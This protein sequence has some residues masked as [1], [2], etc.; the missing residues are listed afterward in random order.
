MCTREFKLP[1]SGCSSSADCR[2][3]HDVF[4]SHPL[5]STTPTDKRFLFKGDVR[6]AAIVV[7]QLHSAFFVSDSLFWAAMRIPLE[8]IKDKFITKEEVYDSISFSLHYNNLNPLLAIWL[9]SS[10]HSCSCHFK[11]YDSLK[12]I[13]RRCQVFGATAARL[14]LYQWTF[15][16]WFLILLFA[17][18]WMRWMKETAESILGLVIGTS[19]KFWCNYSFQRWLSHQDIRI[20]CLLWKLYVLYCVVYHIHATSLTYRIILTGM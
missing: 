4:F 8:S 16:A 3:L 7:V 6:L 1:G 5:C 14:M 20:G 9:F 17:W 15:P 11:E 2:A 10:S 12:S 18:T 19:K 13:L